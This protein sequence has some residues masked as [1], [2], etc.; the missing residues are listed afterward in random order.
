MC[1]MLWLWTCCRYFQIPFCPLESW[2]ASFHNKRSYDLCQFWCTVTPDL[3]I[4]AIVSQRCMLAVSVVAAALFFWW[5]FYNYNRVCTTTPVRHRHYTYDAAFTFAFICF[6]TMWCIPWRSF[7]LLC[8]LVC[9]CF[10]MC[11]RACV[12]KYLALLQPL[13]L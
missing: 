8:K 9:S 6:V 3:T 1:E 5:Y 7:I 11:E 4:V 2:L 13:R 10:D 12:S